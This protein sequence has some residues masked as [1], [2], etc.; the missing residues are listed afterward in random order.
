MVNFDMLVDEGLISSEDQQ[1]FG[2]AE[3][4][5]EGCASLVQRELQ[6]HTPNIRS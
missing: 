2:I 4:A 5:E 6:A 1:L 3:T